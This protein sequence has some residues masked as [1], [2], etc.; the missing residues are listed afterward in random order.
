MHTHTYTADSASAYL[1]QARDGRCRV[2]GA[3][4]PEETT[5][6]MYARA[7]P[8]GSLPHVLAFGIQL[9]ANPWFRG[10][11]ARFPVLHYMPESLD[12]CAV[13]VQQFGPFLVVPALVACD[14]SVC[15]HHLEYPPEGAREREQ[16]P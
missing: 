11:C 4:K 13:S 16:A 15:G 1:I 5:L 12:A 14:G 2:P 8:P 9:A 10:I 6:L 7:Q 3:R